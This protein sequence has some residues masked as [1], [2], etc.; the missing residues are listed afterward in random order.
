MDVTRDRQTLAELLSQQD[1]ELCGIAPDD[2]RLSIAVGGIRYDSRLVAPG[3]IFCAYRGHVHD[4][5]NHAPAAAAAQAALIVAARPLDVGATPVLIH[6]DPKALMGRLADAFYGYPARSLQLVAITGT[7]GKTTTAHVCASMLAARYGQAG[8]LGTLGAATVRAQPGG[9][10]QVTDYA[11]GPGL[12]TPEAP[13]LLAQLHRFVAQGIQA[14]AME[15]SSIALCE[16]RLRQTPVDVAVL[17]NISRDHLDYHGTMQ[18]YEAAKAQLFVAHRKPNGVGVLPWAYAQT[19]PWQDLAQ[20][21]TYSAEPAADGAPKACLQRLAPEG[22]QEGAGHLTVATPQGV[23][24]LRSPLY[25]RFNEENVLAAVAAALALGIPGEAIA[26]GLRDMAPVP[27]RLQPVR[28][29]QSAADGAPEPLVLV[30]FAHTPDALARVLEAV[31]PLAQGR[32]HLVVGCGGD[33][34]PGKRPAMGAVAAQADRIWITSDNPRSE[35][36]EA[37]AQAMVQGLQKATAAPPPFVVELDRARAIASAINQAE[38]GDVVLIAGKGHEPY[39]LIA[40]K[41]WP[42]DDRTCAGEALA[43]WHPRGTL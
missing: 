17:T 37:I 13:D 15:A 11:T 19:P 16:G 5:H 29:A 35:R 1:R 8:L 2:G 21:H 6:P 31:R 7:N 4:G 42:F 12:T 32:L 27:G 9:G 36:P 14:V 39:Q 43:A 28:S 30:D 10:A 23:L 24:Q 41:K 20:T 33:R 38:A 18:A 26:Q 34:D 25:G 22:A 3:D 40:G